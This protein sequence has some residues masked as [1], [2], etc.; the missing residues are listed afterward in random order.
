M[1]LD[2]PDNMYRTITRTPIIN[3]SLSGLNEQAINAISMQG[4]PQFNQAAIMEQATA[5]Q[6]MQNFAVQQN[7]EVPKV[8]FYPSQHVDPRKA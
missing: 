1:V 2:I 5:H 6:Y 3:Q 7:L 8:N 4:N